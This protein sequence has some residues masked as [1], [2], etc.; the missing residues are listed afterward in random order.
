M[1]MCEHTIIVKNARWVKCINRALILRG[2]SDAVVRI[3]YLGESP[4]WSEGTIC[5][6]LRPHLVIPCDHP[7]NHA[8][9]PCAQNSVLHRQYMQLRSEFREVKSWLSEWETYSN[10]E[11]C[12]LQSFNVNGQPEI[13]FIRSTVSAANYT[14]IRLGNIHAMCDT[15]MNFERVKRW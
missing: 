15:V 11:G 3:Q 1:Y 6:W 4:F 7:I 10:T 8:H 5:H 12:A 9:S 2:N 13:A 14:T